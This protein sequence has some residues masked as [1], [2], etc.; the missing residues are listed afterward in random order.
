MSSEP[1]YHRATIVLL[2]VIAVAFLL[3]RIWLSVSVY[4]RQEVRTSP[5]SSFLVRGEHATPADAGYIESWMTFDYVNVVF[6]LPPSY[7]SDALHVTDARYPHLSIS[8]WAREEATTSPAMLGAVQ[9][10]VR[11]YSATGDL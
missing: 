11:G 3:F 7:L 5:L 6:G 1:W 8:R 2:I 10:A 4:P 9:S